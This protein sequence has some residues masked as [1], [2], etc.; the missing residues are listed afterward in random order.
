MR[1]TQQHRKLWIQYQ[2]FLFPVHWCLFVI[3]RLL[4]NKIDSW[5]GGVFQGHSKKHDINP[6]N[7]DEAMSDVDAHLWQRAMDVE[8]EFIYSK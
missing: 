8:L 7:Y 3:W 4:Y 6:T 2:P 1:F 5:F